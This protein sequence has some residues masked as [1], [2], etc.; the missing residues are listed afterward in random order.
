MNIAEFLAQSFGKLAYIDMLL[1]C[2]YLLLCLYIGCRKAGNI[3][4]IKDYAIGV[5]NI[6]TPILVATIYATH[7]GAGATIGIMEKIYHIGL[8]FALIELL[9][10]PIRW[11]ITLVIYRN[12]EQFKNCLTP[13]DIMA[14]LYNSPGRIVMNVGV[15]INSIAI[16]AAQIVALGYLMH[17]FLEIPIFICVLVGAGTV[18]I[19]SMMGGIRAVVVTDVLQFALFYVILPIS[20]VLFI[21]Q[22]GGWGTV[23]NLIPEEK[24]QIWYTDREQMWMLWDDLLYVLL[25][26]STAPFLQRFLMSM[27]RKQITNALS[28]A[29]LLDMTIV[30]TICTF[31]FVMIAATNGIA[32]PQDIIWHVV[33]SAVFDVLKGVFIIGIIAVIMSTA[34]SYLNN[35]GV[36]VARDIIKKGWP[37][38]SDKKEVFWARAFTVLAGAAAIVLV[39]STP[40]I[41]ALV[42][43]S[44]SFYFPVILIPLSAGFLKFRTNTTSFVTSVVLAIFATFL[45]AKIQ[46]SF[47][48]IATVFGIIGSMTGLFG[49]HYLQKAIGKNIVKPEKLE[50]A[51]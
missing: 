26:F 14:R 34:D 10:S 9:F 44:F 8:S 28:I 27:D 2:A 29:A 15:L 36:L 33:D 16:V 24:W 45:G 13:S 22:I 6:S 4:N 20:C 30:L 51:K 37:K 17:Y 25:P 42:W 35:V 38:I 19:Y 21:K 18:I 43:I 31:G 32:A 47:G 50:M 49:M 48:V 7:L 12:I 46:D 1:I 41:L 40:G 3:R 5:G 39:V 11:I 23:Y